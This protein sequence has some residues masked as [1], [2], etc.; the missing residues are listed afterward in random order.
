MTALS[1]NVSKFSRNLC[2][3]PHQVQ[4]SGQVLDITR[5]GRVVARVSPAPFA[6][7]A[8][9]PAAD[10]YPIAQLDAHLARGPRLDPADREAM[11]KDLR[12]Q[13]N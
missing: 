11:V 10:G 13:R 6:S 9:A 12:A 8:G 1:V 3:F 7:S 4:H 5:F 2:D